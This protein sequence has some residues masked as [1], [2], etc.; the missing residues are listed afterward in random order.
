MWNQEKRGRPTKSPFTFFKGI[1]SPKLREKFE[2]LDSLWQGDPMQGPLP[3]VRVVVRSG[4]I[5]EMAVAASLCLHLHSDCGRKEH[6]FV[7][8]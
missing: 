7:T 8:S 6:E 4:A 5:A 3:L 1:F 2:V